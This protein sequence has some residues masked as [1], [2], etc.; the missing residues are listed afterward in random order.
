MES[1]RTIID[2]A[3]SLESAENNIRHFNALKQY[4]SRAD[5]LHK[6]ALDS[7]VEIIKRI[8]EL[9]NTL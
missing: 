3:L 6:F 8:K 9:V 1:V 5:R 7:K 4:N 2:L